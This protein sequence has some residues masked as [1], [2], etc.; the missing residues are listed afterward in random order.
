MWLCYLVLLSC[1]K[2]IMLAQLKAVLIK[3]AVHLSA[4]HQA[5]IIFIK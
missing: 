5:L 2:L 4:E 3:K 1:D